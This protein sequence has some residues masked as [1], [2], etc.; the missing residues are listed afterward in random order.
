MGD[1][2]EAL[3]RIDA[4][5]AAH[6]PNAHLLFLRGRASAAAGKWEQALRSYQK[7]LELEPDYASVNRLV[8]DV[9]DRFSAGDDEQRA[10]AQKILLQGLSTAEGNRRLSAIA[11]MGDGASLRR[12]ARAALEE[13]GRF[14]DLD[15][16]NKASIKLRFATGC[17]EHSRRIE[18]I[19]AADDPRGLEVLRYY[20]ER[21]RD[22]CGT[23][24]QEDCYGCIRDELAEAIAALEPKAPK[25]P[26]A[27]KD[28]S[29]SEDA[30]A[31]DA[32]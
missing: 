24:N 23:F 29:D 20:D 18:A 30:K 31:P 11:R 9:V 6:E 1:P 15:A 8:D 22:G 10:R 5:I 26:K 19:V 27:T 25:A 3:A 14:D 32:N 12:R 4:L 16:W 21:P 17:D 28:D 2:T 7:T 13:N